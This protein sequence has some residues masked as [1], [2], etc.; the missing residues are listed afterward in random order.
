MDDDEGERKRKIRSAWS[1]IV[2]SADSIARVRGKNRGRW[3]HANENLTPGIKAEISCIPISFHEECLLFS[4]FFNCESGLLW[5]P[6]RALLSHLRL[7]ISQRSQV[8]T[9]CMPSQS[10]LTSATIDPFCLKLACV[11]FFPLFRRRPPFHKTKKRRCPPGITA[12]M[13]S[14]GQTQRLLVVLCKHSSPPLVSG[15]LWRSLLWE[16]KT[17]NIFQLPWVMPNAAEAEKLPCKHGGELENVA[18]V[19]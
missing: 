17:G 3:N 11:T 16:M 9:M 15:G 19:Q 13:S 10:V 1:A 18:S 2:Q 12:G 14:F 7:S 8:R 5:Q 6:S 4:F